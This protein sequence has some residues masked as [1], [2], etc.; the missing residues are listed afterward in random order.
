MVKEQPSEAQALTLKKT[1]SQISKPKPTK[2]RKFESKVEKLS[3][4]VFKL[5]NS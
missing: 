3:D 5:L 4:M 2:S 1:K